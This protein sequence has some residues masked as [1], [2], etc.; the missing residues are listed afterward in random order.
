MIPKHTAL[1]L[2]LAGLVIVVS[3]TAVW[4]AVQRTS[5]PEHQQGAVTQ[6]PTFCDGSGDRH[7]GND[8]V[9]QRL[10]ARAAHPT[11]KGGSIYTIQVTTHPGL[12]NHTEAAEVQYR[13][14]AANGTTGQWWGHRR[15]LLSTDGA[16][17][18]VH[19]IAACAPTTPGTYQVRTAVWVTAPKGTASIHGTTSAYTRSNALASS[20]A[21]ATGTLTATPTAALEVP[22]DVVTSAPTTITATPGAASCANSNQD[23]ILVEYFNEIEFSSDISVQ[24]TDTGSAYSLQIT[25]PPP[26]SSSFPG[27]AFDVI[28]ATTS[29]SAQTSCATQTPLVIAK[30]APPSSCNNVTSWQC[31]FIISDINS[32]TKT[33]YSQTVYQITLTSA[34]EDLIPTLQPASLPICVDP[35]QQCLLT[36]VCSLSATKLGEISLCQNA[37]SCTTLTPGSGY[38]YNE[39]VYFQ[40]SIPDQST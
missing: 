27:P 31:E 4:W 15:V 19:E 23:F 10:A 5:Q 1:R 28:L 25:C 37:A 29:N 7:S 11:F 8:C 22:A 2:T 30:S 35:S 14:V 21:Q 38:S 17:R 24:V 32:V 18:D 3:V 9:R 16:N 34:P 36:G 26:P 20:N 13:L 12:R 40:T 39:N 6:S 33:V